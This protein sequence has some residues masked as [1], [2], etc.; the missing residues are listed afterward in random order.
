LLLAAGVFVAVVSAHPNEGP[1]ALQE[2]MARAIVAQGI[3]AGAASI[4]WLAA[5]A[6]GFVTSFG[7]GFGRAALAGACAVAALLLV[8]A[9]ARS[10]FAAPLAALCLLDALRAGG[11]AGTWLLAALV[12]LVLETPSKRNL[13]ALGLLSVVW[14]NLEAAGLFAPLLALAVA[15]GSCCDASSE[16][17]G[18]AG[19][20]E[21]D[22]WIAVGVAALATLATPAGAGFLP[23]AFETLRLGDS[24]HRLAAAVPYNTAPDAYHAGFFVLLALALASGIRAWGLRDALPVAV[25]CVL[26][27]STGAFVPVFGVVAAPVVAANLRG[28]RGSWIASPLAG[29][30]AAAV[31]LAAV[32]LVARSAPAPAQPYELAA[33][34]AAAA[35]PHGV[36]LCSVID[37]CDVAVAGGERAI[38]DGRIAP[39]GDAA[40]TTQRTVATVAR[41]WERE[42]AASGTTAV[43]ASNDSALATLLG[44]STG[45]RD[46]ARDDR[47]TLFE[48]GGRP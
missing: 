7:G 47:A 6:G 10:P 30:L 5:L 22:R 44:L 38:L 28:L 39:Y 21:R 16:G 41:G 26:G 48:K 12:M 1:L 19:R 25:A 8:E 32:A 15:V 45:W 3:P 34:E 14:C 2:W 27:L 29:L 40:R 35:G 13:V 33:R 9:R 23:A 11:G 46:V 20:F 36:L 4:G 37:W 18:L 43:L 31:A 42:L 17:G 24:A